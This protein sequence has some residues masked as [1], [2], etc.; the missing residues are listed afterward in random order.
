MRDFAEQEDGMKRIGILGVGELSEKIVAGIFKHNH[1]ARVYLSPRNFDRAQRLASEFPCE[2]MPDNQAVVDKSE[3][4][5]IG[6]RPESLDELSREVTFSSEQL[7]VSLVAGYSLSDTQQLFGHQNCVRAMLNYAAEVNS[8]TVIMAPKNADAE[9]LFA[10][11]G[12]LVALNTEAEYQVATVSMCMNGWYYFLASQMQSWLEK[13]GL[14]SHDARALVLGNLRDCAAYAGEHPDWSLEDLGK[15]ISTPGTF[16]E[17]G[18]H[19]LQNAG[20]FE[21]WQNA[22][23]DVLNQLRKKR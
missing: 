19:F 18:R 16:T 20:A 17:Q 13:Q 1:L 7:V 5:I 14:E 8:S 9:A 4:V 22:S 23:D 21:A 6:V 15:S 11:L 10:P 12:D 2:I 3:I